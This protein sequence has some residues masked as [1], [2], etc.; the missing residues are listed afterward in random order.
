MTTD[1]PKRVWDPRNLEEFLE[2]TALMAH[3]PLAGKKAPLELTYLGLGLGGETGEAL[4]VIKKMIRRG[5]F[6]FTEEERE[7]FILELGD[8]LWYWVRL[9]WFV[10]SSPEEVI[11]R[12]AEKLRA[13]HN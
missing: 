9:V 6:E 8:V 5:G 11:K 1:N 3:Y 13:R 2:F 7:K 12:N 10:G 4:E